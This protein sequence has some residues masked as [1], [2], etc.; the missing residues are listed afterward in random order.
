[1]LPTYRK[2]VLGN[3]LR[4]IT[5]PLKETDAVTVLAMT[6]VGS[7]YEG[8]SINGIS[9]FLEHMMFKGT[10]KRPTALDVAKELDGVGA[11]YN[12]FTSKDYT[13]YYV[14]VH[15]DHLALAL[16]VMSDILWHSRFLPEEVDR[17][18]K[19]IAEEINMYFD[20]PIMMVEDLFE[21]LIFGKNHPL[22]RL[23]SGPKSVVR[24]LRREDIVRYFRRHYFPANMVVGIA[25]RFREPQAVQGVA[26]L[27]QSASHHRVP[28]RFRPFRAY[29]RRP[30]VHVSFRD[31]EQVQLCLGY[32]GLPYNH[33]DLPALTLLTVILGGNMS[34][35]LFISVREREGLAYSI[36][37]SRSPYHDAGTFT[38][39]AGVDRHRL[40]AAI[41]LILAELKKVRQ[42][43]VTVEELQR[44]KEFLRGKFTLNLED[45]EHIA[46]FYTKQ[47]LLFGKI[48][49]PAE[50]LAEFK[51]VTRADI[52][53]VAR[54]IFRPSLTN[55]ALIG[56]FRQPAVFQRLLAIR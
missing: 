25:G 2:H 54:R 13:G 31:T 10:D 24:R 37:A 8:A 56:P 49:T 1:M 5:A 32:P 35:R 4:L 50:R 55:L 6:K 23:I 22:A 12:A 30:Q 51:R 33:R 11:S 39:Q 46:D 20:N 7:R 19:V 9:H 28:T 27:F 21:Q 53:R 38:V 17:E 29:Q 34:S 48:K 14:K 41:Q 3:Q 45:S 26:K 15:W 42:H 18:R 52:E 44:A 36:H 43:G 47:E 16:D 40:E